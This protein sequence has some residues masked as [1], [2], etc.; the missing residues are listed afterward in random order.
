MMAVRDW[1]YRNLPWFALVLL[2]LWWPPML[3]LLAA[4]AGLVANTGY[5]VL[6]DPSTIAALIELVLLTWGT[7][8]L[9]TGSARGWLYLAWSRVPA[10]LRLGWMAVSLWRL[11]GAAATLRERIVWE[12]VTM[13]VTSVAVLAFVRAANRKATW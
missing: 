4:H 10:L 13:L 12:S 5:A 3:S 6:S 2:A 9:L 11:N 1:L 8:L 7:A